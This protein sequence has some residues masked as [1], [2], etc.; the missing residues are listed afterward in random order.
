[1]PSAT[2]WYT[3][4][5]W[6]TATYWPPPVIN[7]WG[8]QTYPSPATLACQW[9]ERSSLYL[10][11]QGAQAVSKAIVQL[12]VNIDIDGFLF[13]GTISPATLS[14]RTVQGAALIQRVDK[15][16]LPYNRGMVY[17]AY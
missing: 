11:P 2:S 12:E 1:M 5:L 7:E 15:M 8:D 13:L 6:Q 9:E 10:S 3:R 17:V 14:P 16:P 4:Q